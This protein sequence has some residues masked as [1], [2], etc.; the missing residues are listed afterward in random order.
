[1]NRTKKTYRTYCKYAYNNILNEIISEILKME[2]YKEYTP[3]HDTFGDGWNTCVER[4]IGL[5]GELK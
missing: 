4:V 5:I 3:N 1:M 2:N